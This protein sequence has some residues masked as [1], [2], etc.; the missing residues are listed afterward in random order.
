M[1]TISSGEAHKINLFQPSPHPTKLYPRSHG[2]IG[3]V[4]EDLE[5]IKEKA[6][7]TRGRT[8]QQVLLDSNWTRV[9]ARRNLSGTETTQRFPGATMQ[10]RRAGG[11][12]L[13]DLG[14]SQHLG[15]FSSASWQG[16]SG[17]QDSKRQQWFRAL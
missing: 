7:S 5:L 11:L 3:R 10:R 13:E 9:D 16:I 8:I 1:H 4:F 17:S 15:D 2:L 6:K 14:W 12:P